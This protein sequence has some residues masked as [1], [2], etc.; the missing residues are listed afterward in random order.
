L[1][2]I[3]G[4]VHIYPD[5]YLGR[6]ACR[7]SNEVAACINKIITY[8]TNE[9]YT[10]DWFTNFVVIGGDTSPHDDE[11]ID[12]GEYVN[13]AIIDIMDDHRYNGWFYSQ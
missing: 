8:E 10:K 7:D 1:E 13:Q 5:V 3:I 2:N 4:A 9:A 11:N 6:L 12:E